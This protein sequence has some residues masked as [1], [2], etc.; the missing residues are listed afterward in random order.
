M[1]NLVLQLIPFELDW[2]VMKPLASN[3]GDA[4]FVDAVLEIVVWLW[5]LIKGDQTGSDPG[6]SKRL[7]HFDGLVTI[8]IDPAKQS[9]N[10]RRW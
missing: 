4:A 10:C 1:I 9:L 7:A 2:F 6:T 5:R 3:H 8:E